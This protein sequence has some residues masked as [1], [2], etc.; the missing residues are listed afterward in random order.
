MCFSIGTYDNIAFYGQ[1]EARML[2]DAPSVTPIKEVSRAISHGRSWI[3]ELGCLAEGALSAFSR[4]NHLKRKWRELYSSVLSANEDYL[5]D[6][7]H[8]TREHSRL[9]E[10]LFSAEIEVSEMAEEI[11]FLKSCNKV[12]SKTILNLQETQCI[13]EEC[14]ER[15]VDVPEDMRLL[16]FCLRLPNS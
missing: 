13:S 10:A 14:D 6:I 7:N 3:R 11:D 5:D 9:N 2:A 16:Q 1:E 15:I 4:A 12:Q 8:L